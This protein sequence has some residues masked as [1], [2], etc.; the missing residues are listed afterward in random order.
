MRFS[1]ARQLA[2]QINKE[3]DAYLVDPAKL[4]LLADKLK[5]LAGFGRFDASVYGTD[6]CLAL[7]C[8]QPLVGR[9]GDA[10]LW[11]RKKY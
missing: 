8:Y 5:Q 2:G 7:I 9:A 1:K 4:D 6:G 3:T 11:R 10:F